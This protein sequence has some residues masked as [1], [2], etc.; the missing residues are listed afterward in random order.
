MSTDTPDARD[1][2]LLGALLDSWDR[3]N[4]IVINLLRA[5]P[6]DDHHGQIKIALKAMGRP[7]D[8]EEIG[9]VTWD[10]WMEKD[11]WPRRRSGAPGVSAPEI[12]TT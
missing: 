2:G 10:L 7:F 11:K 4:A 8:D 5:L 9:Q 6:D 12:Q 3:N 1:N